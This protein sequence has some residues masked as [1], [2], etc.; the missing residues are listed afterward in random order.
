MFVQ[1]YNFGSELLLRFTQK[2]VPHNSGDHFHQFFELE[3]IFDGE[4]EITLNGKTVTARAG[5]IAIIP[6]FGVHSF[7]TPKSVKMLIC[8][9]SSS[10]VAGSYSDAELLHPR[11]THV[12]RP[13][14]ALWN[15]LVES[16]F[17]GTHNAFVFDMQK[18]AD[19]FV[20]NSAI[21]RL[22]FSEYF[23]AVPQSEVASYDGALP[24]VLS[25]MSSH[26]TENITLK[27]VGAAIGYTPKY[28][29][30]CL[31]AM[32]D[33]N[34][35]QLLNSMR[36]ER[37]KELLRSTDESNYEIAVTS[38]FNSECS[39]HR[40]FKELE[41]CTPGKYRDKLKKSTSN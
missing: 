16:G 10:F 30:N 11:K 37:A 20:K 33:I 18:D 34:F 1:H 36:T 35:R 31:S 13:S 26:F 19:E 6:A 4:I 3:M 23:S 25:Y 40:V 14:S 8:V 32:P 9:F 29:S 12:F 22:I 17:A 24:K 7:Y 2:S 21:F 15:Y 38:G 28:I 39:F 41:G 5:D 27:S